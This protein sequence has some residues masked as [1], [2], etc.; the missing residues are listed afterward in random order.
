MGQKT[1]FLGHAR[2]LLPGVFLCLFSQQHISD[3]LRGLCFIFL[4]DVA[5]ETFCCGDA[6]MTK[7]FR[8]RY[9][10]GSVCQQHRGNRVPKCVRIDVGQAV[11]AGEVIEPIGD[12]VRV[13]VVAVVL[14]KHIA[15]INPPSPI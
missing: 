3:A 4:N 14:R 1:V 11:A 15:G 6:C 2:H 10:V 8:Y 7:L 12:T 9:N 13:H 5:V